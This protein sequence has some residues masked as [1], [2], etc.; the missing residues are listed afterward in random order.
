SVAS[1]NDGTKLAAVDAGGQIYTS[2]DSGVTW[3]AHFFT[4]SWA[5]VTSSADGTRLAAVVAG[6]QIYVSSD[7]GLSW[8]PR[9]SNRL[10]FSIASSADG[11]KLVSVVTNGQIYTSNPLALTT[12]TTTGTAGFLTGGQ[13]TAIELQYIGNGLFIP[14]SHEG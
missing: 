5:D 8:T 9:E 13:S 10:W 14:L 11:S 2:S 12:S 1:S 4:R 7:S 6:G 3:S